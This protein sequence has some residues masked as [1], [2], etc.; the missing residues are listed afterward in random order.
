MPSL[1]GSGG[2]FD[3]LQPDREISGRTDG[4]TIRKAHQNFQLRLAK[5]PI[6]NNAKLCIHRFIAVHF[7]YGN[8]LMLVHFSFKARNDWL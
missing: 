5:N 6:K 8:R 4:Q 2:K 3:S 1:I 7:M